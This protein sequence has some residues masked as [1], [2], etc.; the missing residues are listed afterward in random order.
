M[1]ARPQRLRQRSDARAQAHHGAEAGDDDARRSPRSWSLPCPQ[2]D[3]GVGAAEAQARRD[4]R[5]QLRQR[6]RRVVHQVDRERGIDAVAAGGGVDLASPADRAP[7]TT[8][9]MAPAVPSRWPSMPL[10]ASI[11]MS[12]RALAEHARERGGL[13]GVVERRA[14]A[15]GVDEVDFSADRGRRPRALVRSPAP[16]PPARR[17]ARSCGWRRRTSPRPGARP[18]AR[19]ALDRSARATRAPARRRPRRATC[20]PGRR[21][22]AGTDLPPPRAAR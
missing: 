6:Q 7:P 8:A 17:A 1:I 12:P 5:A 19:P 22:T 4:R 11:G 14:G 9:S 13:G 20:R 21:G 18:A 10:V 2:D 16:R 3:G 15:V